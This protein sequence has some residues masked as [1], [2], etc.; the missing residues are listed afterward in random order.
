MKDMSS[1]FNVKESEIPH[2]THLAKKTAWSAACK[3]QEPAR[4]EIK[5]E[6]QK[7]AR[8]ELLMARK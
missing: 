5:A 1:N 2:G 4:T 3:R 6:T 8:K 7:N